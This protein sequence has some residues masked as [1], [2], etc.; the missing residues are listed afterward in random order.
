MYLKIT[1]ISPYLQTTPVLCLSSFN[2]HFMC[3][4]CNSQLTCI[5]ILYPFHVYLHTMFTHYTCILRKYP[6]HLLSSDN[7]YFT[8]SSD[9]THFT[10]IF[11]EHLFHQCLNA[12][13]IPPVSLNKT[14]FTHI[15]KQYPFHLYLKTTTV[16]PVS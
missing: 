3:I 11:R 1:S 13:P 5:F 2:T 6:F 16:L 12:T 7:A 14:H 8:S 4:F 9:N 10:R 15:I